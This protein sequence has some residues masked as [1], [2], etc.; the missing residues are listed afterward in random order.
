MKTIKILGTG[1]PKCKT[2]TG[3]V[4]DVVKE[5]NIDATIEK[6][7]DIMEIMKYNVLS[8]PVLVIDE[9]IKIKG[10]VPSPKEVLELLK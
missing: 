6:V 3:I 8:T 2:M 10:R 5:N 7:E 9:Q 4:Q 1:C